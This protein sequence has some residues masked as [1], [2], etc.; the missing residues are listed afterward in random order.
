[1]NKEGTYCAVGVPWAPRQ[2]SQSFADPRIRTAC[3]LAKS[4]LEGPSC[5]T[6]MWRNW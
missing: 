6:R 4:P 5:L 3:P 1:M 2:G